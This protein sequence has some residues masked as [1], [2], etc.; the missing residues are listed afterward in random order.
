MLLVR[1]G[2]RIR[3]FE[4]NLG[5]QDR[6]EVRAGGRIRHF[7]SNLGIQDR[8]EVRVFVNAKVNLD[9]NLRKK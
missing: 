8:L 4:S 5:I 9:T 6:L 1:A 7:E 2:G 3:H